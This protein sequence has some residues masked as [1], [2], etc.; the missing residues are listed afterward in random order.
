MRSTQELP[1][2]PT[3]VYCPSL[4]TTVLFGPQ[5]GSNG[6]KNPSFLISLLVLGFE[7]L[8]SIPPRT[9]HAL[10]LREVASARLSKRRTR[11]SVFYGH[12]RLERLSPPF[13]IDT[14][15]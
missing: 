8:G 3:V 10:V 15:F 1:N 2:N 5:M 14:Q 9:K 12:T 13:F 6:F 7:K 11:E 4:K